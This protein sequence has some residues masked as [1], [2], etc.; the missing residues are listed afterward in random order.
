MWAL[1]GAA[2]VAIIVVSFIWSAA[3]VFGC[4]LFIAAAINTGSII[5]WIIGIILGLLAIFTSTAV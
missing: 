3:L 4:A 5:C 1:L 2:L